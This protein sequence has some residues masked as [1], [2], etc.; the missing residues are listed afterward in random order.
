MNKDEFSVEVHLS[1]EMFVIGNSI[2][3][4]GLPATTRAYDVA[5][6]GALKNEA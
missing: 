5:G 3:L 4:K 6:I 1:V 2:V